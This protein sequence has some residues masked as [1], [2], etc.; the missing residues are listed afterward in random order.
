MNAA[1]DPDQRA[2]LVVK[3]LTL[4]EKIQLVHGIGW[5]PL[6]AVA[7]ALGSCAVAGTDRNT[8]E[9]RRTS[10]SFIRAGFLCGKLSFYLGKMSVRGAA[11]VLNYT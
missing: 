1:L 7:D 10:Q 3:Q 11:C 4:A 6:R 9:A 8:A 2:D 5:G